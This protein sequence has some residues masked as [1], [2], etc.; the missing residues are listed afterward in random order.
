[1]TCV[2]SI[3]HIVSCSNKIEHISEIKAELQ[4][5]NT[6]KEICHQHCNELPDDLSNVKAGKISRGEIKTSNT[7]QNRTA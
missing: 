2:K 7:H 1:M 4:N 5:A 6:E 3:K